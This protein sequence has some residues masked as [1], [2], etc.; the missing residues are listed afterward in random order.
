MKETT[1]IIGV[2]IALIFAAF[3]GGREYQASVDREQIRVAENKIPVMERQHGI[4]RVRMV[5]RDE[6]E[7]DLKRRDEG[8]RKR[9]SENTDDPFVVER[10]MQGMNHPTAVDDPFTSADS[11]DLPA[12]VPDN[13]SNPEPKH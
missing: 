9:E 3:A 5:D 6:H 2:S 7:R 11:R 4:T 1:I 12:F 13:N 8:R 10:M